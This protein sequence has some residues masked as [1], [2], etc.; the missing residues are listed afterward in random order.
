MLKYFVFHELYQKI[1]QKRYRKKKIFV[2]RNIEVT[3][4][5][6]SINS[7][8]AEGASVR[9]TSLGSFSSIGRN[10]KISHCNIGKFCAISWDCTIGAVP[11]P[12]DNISINAFPYKRK[13]GFIE[14]D[15][16][17]EI[18]KVSIGNDVWI[19]ANSVILSGVEIGHGAV[20][21][22]GAVVTKDVPPYAI[23]VG[24]PAK[25][26]KYR[27]SEDIIEELLEIKWWDR[28]EK[29][30]QNNINLF[31]KKLTKESLKELKKI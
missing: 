21:G 28:D 26:I 12:I 13:M 11:H 22:A 31:Q 10:S 18:R 9:E 20:I 24:V 27:F 16:R 8:V 4:S 7:R 15:I 3:N 14:E 29:S 17:L 23:V 5:K 1:L 19:G 6:L 25:V 30:L 2:G